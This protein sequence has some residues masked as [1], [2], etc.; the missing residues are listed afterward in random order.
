M[1]S[2]E[3]TQQAIDALARQP[4]DAPVFML[5]LLRYR[6]ADPSEYARYGATAMP[7]IAKRGGSVLYTGRPLI[8][9]EQIGWDQVI[10]VRYPTRAAFVDM[11]ADADYQAGLPHRSAGLDDTVLYAFRAGESE[12]APGSPSD[13]TEPVQAAD[14]DE[15]FV[16]NLLRFKLDG[17]R[18]DYTKYGRVAGKLIQERRGGPVM[19]L[20]PELPLIGDE[21]WDEL[22]L[23]RYPSLQL[24][25]GMIE[26]DTW[27]T[28]NVDRERGLDKTV[29]FPTR[30]TGSA[31]AQS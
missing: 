22:I 24:L 16:L 1:P 6:D 15:I 26:T 8:P 28:A 19:V 14:S 29:A 17:G 18:E 12:L 21:T 10:I 7:Q 9:R 2:V 3:I 27:K 11:M 4:D 30:P 5:N 13:Y 25:M 23:V 20:H 31:P